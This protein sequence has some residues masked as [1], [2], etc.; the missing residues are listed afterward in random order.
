[1]KRAP[2]VLAGTV[3]GLAGLLAFHSRPPTATAGPAPR[4]SS[5]GSGAATSQPAASGARPAAG[6][7]RSAAGAVEQYGY[8]E[9]Q[10]KVTA[11]GRRITGVS[12]PL[13]RTAE[14][15]SQQLAGRA[16]PQLRSEVL[17]G[18]TAHINGISGATYTSRAYALSVQAALDKLHL[19]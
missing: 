19:Q 2:F 10:V 15:Y 18:Q 17:S 8:G 4:Q 13:L 7:A 9:L 16:I 5:T 3:A 14:P 12:V 11:A 6:G 1:M